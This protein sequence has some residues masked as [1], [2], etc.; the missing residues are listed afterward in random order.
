M[1][2]IA[3][4]LIC[5]FL[6]AS[7][8]S[9]VTVQITVFCNGGIVYDNAV[10]VTKPN[11]TA[12]DAIKAS[13][14]AHAPL[15]YG[16]IE[17]LAGCGGWPAFYINGGISGEGVDQYHISDGDQLQ[18]L[19]PGGWGSEPM[20][21]YLCLA[22]VPS[23]VAKGQGFRI[24]VIEK[25][26][27][28][29]D[30]GGWGERPS[31][32]ATVIVGNDQYVTGGDGYTQEITL[33]KDAFY[34][35]GAEKGGYI[36]TYLFSDTEITDIQCGAGGPYICSIR[37][38]GGGAN[39]Y[40]D[41]YS[42]VS[43]HGY[44]SCRCNFGI[45]VGK[46]ISRSTKVYQKG[47]GD[48][49]AERIVKQTPA[50]IDIKES[51]EM[52]YQPSKFEAYSRPV[53]YASKYE[54]SLHLKNYAM[55]SD[56]EEK[57]RQLDYINRE[58]IFNNSDKI[59][60]SSQADFAG[61]AVLHARDLDEDALFA[62]KG[63]I[64]LKGESFETYI[65]NFRI[66]RRG[67]VPMINETSD[68]EEDCEDKCKEKCKENCTDCEEYCTEHCENYCAN[69]TTEEE[70]ELL[71]CCTGGWSLMVP[72]DQHAHCANC[73]FDS[74]SNIQAAETARSEQWA[75]A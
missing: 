70:Y 14:M 26:V 68:D 54:D 32:G 31:S 57:Y 36:P 41:E 15:S 53:S 44:S 8:A 72:A 10:T 25:S 66:L 65:G 20:A 11:P 24:K 50:K 7:T 16:M 42:S 17:S 35:V 64:D 59:R 19:G 34:C 22:H 29:A 51:S 5:I 33:D 13:G 23:Q 9:A 37:I 28:D 47:S 67:E 3:L 2:H 12:Y 56:Y 6:I 1:R 63:K 18:F 75:K 60:Y 52:I 30:M 73:I 39:I 74:T 69:E 49:N 27:Y 43:G 40:Y 48:Y 21:G 58:G 62:E 71:P 55:S 38:S 61:I 4:A 46:Q 45:P